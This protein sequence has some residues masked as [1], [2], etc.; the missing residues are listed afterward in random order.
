M[1]YHMNK[2]YS[3]GPDEISEKKW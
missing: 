3:V 1:K 2:S